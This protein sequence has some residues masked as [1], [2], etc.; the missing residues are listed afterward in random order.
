M[1]GIGSYNGVALAA[2]KDG[3]SGKNIGWQYL[4]TLSGGSGPGISAQGLGI[5]D[6][7]LIVGWSR[8]TTAGNG[9]PKAVVWE[10]T[11]QPA[12]TDL[13]TKIPT[14][15]Q[16]VWVLQRAQAINNNGVIVGTGTKVIGGVAQPRAFLLTPNP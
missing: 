1:F 14:A 9:N 5:N 12:A 6:V 10:N 3:H 15:D 8:T 2:Y 13:N 11:L 16:A 4:G 7:G